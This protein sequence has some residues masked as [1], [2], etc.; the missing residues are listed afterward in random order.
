MLKN[1]VPRVLKIAGLFAVAALVC[2]AVALAGPSSFG[3]GGRVVTGPGGDP[4]D[5]CTPAMTGKCPALDSAPVTLTETTTTTDETTT[6]ETTTD[7]TTTD[8]STTDETSTDDTST[9]DGSVDEGTSDD[10]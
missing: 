5:L 1:D 2:T 4:A 6:D 10:D 8:E 3:E 9:D 7:E